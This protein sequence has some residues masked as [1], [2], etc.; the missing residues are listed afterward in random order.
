[1]EAASNSPAGG[2]TI[3]Y[4]LL[5]MAAGAI[6]ATLTTA[7]GFFILNS[8]SFSPNNSAQSFQDTLVFLGGFHM[9]V[10]GTPACLLGGLVAV[11]PG[12]LLARLGKR[13]TALLAVLA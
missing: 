2:R 1:M 7:V 4:T 3:G 6:A 10:C 9:L 12:L 5:A 8:S 11:V 13:G